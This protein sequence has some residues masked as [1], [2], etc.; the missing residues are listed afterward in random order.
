[1]DKRNAGMVASPYSDALRLRAV[2]RASRSGLGD[3]DGRLAQK[4]RKR[5]A[6]TALFFVVAEAT[7]H[8]DAAGIV[9]R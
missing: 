2:N 6:S 8:K 1:M 5:K 3:V 4:A 7:T 9:C